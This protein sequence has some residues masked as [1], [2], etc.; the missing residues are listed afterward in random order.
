MLKKESSI[1]SLSTTVILN[2]TITNRQS[3]STSPTTTNI[4]TK[5]KN[6]L[7][8]ICRL[9]IIDIIRFFKS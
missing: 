3:T 6:P 7:C 9:E 4:L 5:S 8:P 2:D 1:K